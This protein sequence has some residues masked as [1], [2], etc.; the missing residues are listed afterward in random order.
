[1]NHL[2]E[3]QFAELLAAFPRELDEIPAGSELAAAH[4]HA[5]ECADCAAEFTR[6]RESLALFREAGTA[7]AHTHL[8]RVASWQTPARRSFGFQPAYWAAAA[9]AA[10][11]AAFIP[12]QMA[13]RHPAPEPDQQPIQTVAQRTPAETDQALLDDVNRELSE[14]VPTPMA[15]LLDPAG[16]STEASQNSTQRIN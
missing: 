16:S 7:Y 13:L 8:H 5:S 3:Q 11:L 4:I 2:T 15:A 9:A 14:S 10:L 1:M 12:L 6:M